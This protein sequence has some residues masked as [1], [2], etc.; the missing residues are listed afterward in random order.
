MKSLYE[1]ERQ[2]ALQE[3]AHLITPDLITEED[4]ARLPEPVQRFFR[5]GGYV[6]RERMTNAQVVWAHSEIRMAPDR[7]W[8]RLETHQFN[9]VPEPFRIAYMKARIAGII[10]FEGRDLYRDGRGHMLG[11]ILNLFK[12][13]DAQD[14]E[15]AQSALVTVFAEAF[16]VPSYALQSYITWEEWGEG[17]ARARIRHKGLEAVGTFFFNEADEMVRFETGDRYYS[18]PEGGYEKVRFSAFVDGYQD[19][20]GLRIPRGVRAVWHLEGE[21]YE[22]W[23]GSIQEVRFDVRR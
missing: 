10:P 7:D 19:Q 12:V 5:R 1:K 8:M 22:Y 14:P 17:W 3:H 23:R 13:V 16:L 6:G 20:E 18:R 21:D 9:S 15:I 2:D 4:M 11:K